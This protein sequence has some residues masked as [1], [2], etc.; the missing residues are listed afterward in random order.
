MIDSINE[1]LELE[2]DDDRLAGLLDRVTIATS[3]ATNTSRNSCACN[4]SSSGS[5]TGWSTTS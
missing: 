2:I 5:R 3:I 4:A 1:E